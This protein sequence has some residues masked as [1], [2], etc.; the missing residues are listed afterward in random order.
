ME[1]AIV[2]KKKL[3]KSRSNNKNDSIMDVSQ[4]S[5]LFLI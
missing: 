4:D 1:P 2:K 5:S 3:E